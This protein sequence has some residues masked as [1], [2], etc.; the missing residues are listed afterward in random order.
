MGRQ[1]VAVV[2][3]P[4]VQFH[5]DK[6]PVHIELHPSRSWVESSQVSVPTTN[7]SPHTELQTLGKVFEPPE[8]FQPGFT[9]VHVE[10]QPIKNLSSQV[11]GLILNP[12]PQKEE[13]FDEEVGVPP[14]QATPAFEPVSQPKLHPIPSLVPSS[15]FSG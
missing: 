15:Q 13:Q 4:P 12:S 3:F 14:V 1:T 5:P 10:L 9:P 6:T 8:Q 7:P 2:L 11:S